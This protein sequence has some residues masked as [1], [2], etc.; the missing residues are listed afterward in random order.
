MYTTNTNN[1]SKGISPRQTILFG[2]ALAFVVAAAWTNA[3]NAPFILDDHGTILENRSIRGFGAGHAPWNPPAG[4]SFAGR[5]LTNF[6]FVFDYALWGLNPAGY[7]AVNILL[8]L[9][10]AF[11][12]MGIAGRTFSRWDFPPLMRQNAG[13]LAFGTALLWAVH[14]FATGA[15]TYITQRCEVL[16]AL[17]FLGALYCAIR[18]WQGKRTAIWHIAAVTCLVAGAG[19]KEV[20]AAAPFVL[21]AYDRVFYKRSVRQAL[22]ASPVLYAGAFVGLFI[23][24]AL[25]AT[26]RQA[27]TSFTEVSPLAYAL[28]QTQVLFYYL[29]KAFWPL[30]LNFDLWWREPAQIAQAW[31]FV[32][33]TAMLL[34]GGLFL[35]WKK[36]PAGFAGA[37]FFLVLAPSS[38][39]FPLPDMAV[40]YRAYL[41][42]AAIAAL[43]AG[44]GAWLLIRTVKARWFVVWAAI[45]AL[46]TGGL[47]FATTARNWVFA[48]KVRLWTDTVQKSPLNPRAH[49]NLGAALVNREN[50]DLASEHLETALA[51]DPKCPVAHNNLASFYT[52]TGRHNKALFHLRQAVSLAPDN[53]DYHTSLGIALTHTDQKEAAIRAYQ[54]ALVLNP[55]LVKARINLTN[56]LL[57]HG[58]RQEAFNL[59]MDGLERTPDDAAI[60]ANLGGL[61]ME[62]GSLV[63][64]KK[65]LE[66]SL[67][68]NAD[69]STAHGNMGGLYL[70]LGQHK[71]AI[72]HLKQ[73]LAIAPDRPDILI[74][75]GL[76][77]TQA[78]ENESA[79]R[80]YQQSLALNPH[81]AQALFNLASLLLDKGQTHEAIRLFQ[82]VV[83]ENP[84]HSGA[85]VNM[86]AILF[87]MGEFEQAIICF[88][89][90][91]AIDPQMEAARTNLIEAQKALTL[92]NKQGINP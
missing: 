80:A 82:Q 44:G 55:Y 33:M 78:G 70:M 1:G 74:L 53:A 40:E 12:L 56:L 2:L 18:G 7:R 65:H 76:A 42:V 73:A 58:R 27:A 16:M 34:G 49:V 15:V 57:E 63:E 69:Q 37:F 50:F 26:G 23:L 79:I 8:H 43:V 66:R 11:L 29:K 87:D 41:P 24:I 36:H 13:W 62:R 38:S 92:P 64:A 14:P 30:S 54:Q 45:L 72:A 71:K 60:L 81:S 84:D 46:A 21:Y 6:S 88:E 22:A 47:F 48:D 85:W 91:L 90:A 28:T 10:C 5:P 61:L 75:L 52:R 17:F 4:T 25:V 3:I 32:I 51:L 19:A 31:P 77:F 86:G 68:L 67:A 35:F 9:F 59:L 89:N 83:L 39:F 20:I